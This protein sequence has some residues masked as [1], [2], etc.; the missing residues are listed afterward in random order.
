MTSYIG[1]GKNARVATLNER[2]GALKAYV[3][4]SLAIVVGQED[5]DTWLDAAEELGVTENDLDKIC[6]EISNEL[7][8]RASKLPYIPVRTVLP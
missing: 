5:W 2:R 8:R 6:D 7:H 1:T 4:S 3:L